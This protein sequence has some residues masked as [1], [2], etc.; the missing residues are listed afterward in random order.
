MVQVAGWPAGANV[1]SFIMIVREFTAVT[2]AEAKSYLDRVQAGET[3][4]LR[5]EQPGQSAALAQ[6]L[7]RFGVVSRAVVQDAEPS[8]A[9]DRPRSSAFPESLSP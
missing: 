6:K 8:V 7:L 9:P 2:L 4:D 5:P 1:M 3:V